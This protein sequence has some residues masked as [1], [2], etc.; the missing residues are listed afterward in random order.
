MPYVAPAPEVREPSPVAQ[1]LGNRMQHIH[2]PEGKKYDWGAAIKLLRFAKGWSQNDL[3][4]EMNIY[5]TYISKTE[6]R[7][8]DPT[9]RT[10]E[11]YAEA[12]GVSM[13][14]IVNIAQIA[15]EY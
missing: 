8:T 15:A 11:R 1:A 9:L 10:L 6:S 4:R 12:L 2:C 14:E 5:R 3:A 7:S 13:A